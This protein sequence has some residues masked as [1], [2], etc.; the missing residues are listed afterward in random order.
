LVAGVVQSPQA[1][2]LSRLSSPQVSSNVLQHGDQLRLSVATGVEAADVKD[3]PIRID[4]A[5]LAHVPLIG[6][7]QL[8]G[9]R[10]PDAERAVQQEGIRR[11][12]YRQ[13]Q[14]SL[15]LGQRKVHRVM[16]AGAVERPGL[17]ELPAGSADVF[18]ALSE[19]GRL[20]PQAD[21]VIEVAFP[22]EQTPDG[23]VLPGRSESI[24]LVRAAAQGGNF[25]LPDGAAVMVPRREPQT[26]HVDGLVKQS[27]KIALPWDKEFRLLDAVAEAGGR[28]LQVADKVLVTR[29]D[30]VSGQS[31][32]IQA[33]FRQAQQNERENLVLAAGDVVRVQE[34][35]GTF[36]LEMMQSF[37]RFGFNSSVSGF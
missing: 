13:P 33:S 32:V 14:V 36:V 21:T 19:S 35:P 24:D 20:E 1:L 3:H 9:L 29:I 7:V 22:A 28:R 23:R 27:K 26:I 25:R 15:A 8:A 6:A 2:D 4:D 12:I 34:T 16:V 5:G 10:L 17:K 30:P 31:R 18:S 11:G 37:L